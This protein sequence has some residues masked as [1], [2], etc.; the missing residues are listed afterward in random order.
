MEGQT[1]SR[2]QEKNLPYRNIFTR[3]KNYTF[4]SFLGIFSQKINFPTLFPVSVLKRLQNGWFSKK[5]KKSFLH[6]ETSIETWFKY[7]MTDRKKCIF[8][9]FFLKI[10]GQI[11]VVRCAIWYHV[12]NLKNVK[13]A[14]GG[15]LLFVKLQ[16]ETCN[17]TKSN[18][19]PW[20]FFT[21]FKLYEWYQIAQ[22]STY[23]HNNY[24][25]NDKKIMSV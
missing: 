13:N 2:G 21:L 19:P 17:F 6:H 16:A 1:T 9:G 11:Y 15:V 23:L 25:M 22:S 24:W 20:V 12:H 5:K 10:Y 18:A 14:H 8:V 7:Q 3:K 4:F